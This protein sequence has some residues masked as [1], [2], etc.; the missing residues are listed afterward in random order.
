[1][2]LR[3]L[4]AIGLP[5]WLVTLFYVPFL[6]MIFFIIL[7]V[8]ESRPSLG[9]S[10]SQTKVEA[11]GTSEQKNMPVLEQSKD[12]HV[13]TGKVLTIDSWSTRHPAGFASS[14]M[15]LKTQT[16]REEK[17]LALMD[18]LPQDGFKA[19]LVA[20]ALPVPIAVLAA[21]FSVLMLGT[22]GWSIFT[23]IPFIASIAASI[24]YGWRKQ[25]SLLQCISVS[26]TSLLIMA[27]ILLVIPFEGIICLLMAAPLAV[28]IGTVGGAVGY[29]HSGE[30]T[31]Q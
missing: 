27:S 28:G 1:M 22:Y 11:L 21:L 14:S 5:P 4:K 2:T 25:R 3:R 10:E 16:P 6:N 7:T 23:A 20:A 9:D 18:K 15:A 30:P 12:N 8:V 24:L 26:I 13:N 17:F 19:I 29:V 31:P